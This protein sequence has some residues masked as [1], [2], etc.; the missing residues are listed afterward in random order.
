LVVNAAF[1]REIKDDNRH[2]KA[3]WDRLLPMLSHPETAR[4]HW[5]EL[6]S[7]LAELRDQLAIHFSLEEAYGYF[8]EAIDAAPRLSTQAEVLRS[9]HADLFGM[10]RDLAD[11]ILEFDGERPEHVTKLLSRF[12]RFRRRFE[13]HEEA[14]LTLILESLDD[15]LGVGD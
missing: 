15:D 11:G 4:N 13:R 10:I 8:D 9:E 5:R 12:E 2:L 7:G 3:L 1:L 6:I 14:E